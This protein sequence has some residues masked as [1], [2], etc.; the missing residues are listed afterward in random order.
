MR[1]LG[2]YG[3]RKRLLLPEPQIPLRLPALLFDFGWNAE[4][5][6]D[7]ER[8]AAN[9]VQL[10]GVFVVG[11]G[12][13]VLLPIAGDPAEPDL[14]VELASRTVA[15]RSL[16]VLLV[17][18]EAE[19]SLDGVKVV[20]EPLLEQLAARPP[21]LP[22]G[23]VYLTGYV[24][25]RL[26]RDWN[27]EPAGIF[28]G[29]DGREV[30]LHRVGTRHGDRVPWHN[31]RILLQEP[32]YL[33]RRGVEP[34]LLNQ[35]TAP[36]LRIEGPLGCG[37]SR[38]AWEHLGPRVK[39]G[40]GSS[41][42]PAVVWIPVRSPRFRAST[43]AVEVLGRSFEL[44]AGSSSREAI[45]AA[46]WELGLESLLPAIASAEP[47]SDG[48]AEE[49]IVQAFD[50]LARRLG[51]PVRL[52]F[53][54]LQNAG[55]EGRRLIQGLVES[56]P[57]D[58]SWSL[59]LINRQGHAWPEL[60]HVPLVPVPPMTTDE[61]NALSSSLFSGLS[62]PAEVQDRLRHAAG[63]LPLALEEGLLRMIHLKELRRIYGNYF[64]AGD[65]STGYRASPHF[66]QLVE[67]EAR[68]LGSADAM[69]LLAV[70]HMSVPAAEIA[71][72][73]DALGI[74]V[75]T[76]WASPFA[77]AG[78]LQ[79]QP[80][81]WGSGVALRCEALELALT[82]TITDQAAIV[83]RNTLGEVLLY[84]S[85]KPEAR[86]QTYNLLSGTAAA[87]PP[88]LEL[89]RG[90]A[91]AAEVERI[92]DSL[93]KEL[94]AHRQR[95]GD[96]T[97]ELHLLWTLLPLAHRV[98][99]LEPYQAELERA[100]ALS[101][102][103]PRKHL[104]FASLKTELDLVKG[105]LKEGEKTLRSAL[106]LVVDEDPGRQALLLL[107][108]ARLLTRQGRVGEARTLLEQLLPVLEQRKAV[109]L[110]AQCR[111]LLGNV[112]L[113]EDRL[114]D[115]LELHRSALEIRRKHGLSK[116][117]GSSLSAMGAVSIALGDYVEALASYR[118][119]EQVLEEHG[120]VGEVSYALLGLGRVLRR[121]GDFPSAAI[122]LKRAL[123]LRGAGSDL[124]GEA[125][126]RLVLAQNEL[127][128]GRVEEALTEARRASFDLRLGP[129][130]SQLGDAELLLGRIYLSRSQFQ[131]ARLHL[132]TAFEIHHRQRDESGALLDLSWQLQSA[133]VEGKAEEA[134][135][136]CER[137]A[138]D[139]LVLRP[140]ERSEIVDFRLYKARRWLREHDV[141]VP[142]DAITYLRRAFVEL[143]RKAGH[144]DTELR[145]RY[146]FQVPENVEILDAATEHQLSLPP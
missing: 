16:R 62:M 24:A 82:S 14:G 95:G 105:R 73:A 108:L 60:A 140:S 85:D 134:L 101:A 48:V 146:L 142:D 139:R 90:P 50:R 92:L 46:V 2:S 126:T 8:V 57:R 19:V 86:W 11:I 4:G 110:G 35:L 63:G 81:P 23:H 10:P 138:A 36:A 117:L 107:Q 132:Q 112:A 128:L 6:H 52:V 118:E 102:S 77:D 33:A 1:F 49:A 127:D 145:H 143:T 26:G 21:E 27:L 93:A 47:L 104:A 84:N 69:R 125:I 121:L 133:L 123:A 75:S 51:R 72:A 17:P 122:P 15:A 41:P 20:A 83:A 99:R 44:A 116:A 59:V 115:A 28:R 124:L 91:T 7:F 135:A 71:S 3:W 119:A 45:E 96:A 109:A 131:R 100:L 12:R 34:A 58:G 61:L 29:S 144:L 31:P 66:I 65:S 42:G 68:A 79:R 76:G 5:G 37:K 53:D 130:V 136:L 56:T 89:A 106:G 32:P 87:V 18:V 103:Q 120:D 80:S 55:A 43:L 113:H 9:L 70:A 54:D 114:E 141:P 74:K 39:A 94:A 137:I 129:E 67:A 38:L 64:F 40:R 88:I 25:G 13:I 30:P 22:S 111:F 98:G 97:T 78:W